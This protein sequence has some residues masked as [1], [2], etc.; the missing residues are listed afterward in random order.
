MPKAEIVEYFLDKNCR[1]HMGK[2]AVPRNEH[3]LRGWQLD[4]LE[5]RTAILR[6]EMGIF[7]EPALE[8]S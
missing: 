1:T 3:R 2:L 5:K 7:P 4:T 8:A 6:R